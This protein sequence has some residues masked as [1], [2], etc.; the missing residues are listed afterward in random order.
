MRFREAVTKVITLSR[1]IRVIS[2][3]AGVQVSS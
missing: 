2:P 1:N 3:P